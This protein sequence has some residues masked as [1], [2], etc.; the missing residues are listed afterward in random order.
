MPVAALVRE[1]WSEDAMERPSFRRVVHKLEA[2]LERIANSKRHAK[3]EAREVGG[4]GGPNREVVVVEEGPPQHP[5]AEVVAAAVMPSAAAGAAPVDA[6][7]EPDKMPSS[8]G[9]REGAD[10]EDATA[11]DRPEDEGDGITEQQHDLLENM[12]EEHLRDELADAPDFP[13]LV[14]DW[15]LLRFLGY[16]QDPK[17]ASAK[18]RRMLEW[19]RKHGVDAMRA[20]IVEERLSFETLPDADAI[21]EA[22]YVHTWSHKRTLEGDAILS[23]SRAC[24]AKSTFTDSSA[25]SVSREPCST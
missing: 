22:G 7:A 20:R 14:G 6:A 9:A 2:E 16:K 23:S 19:R 4:V 5:S 21:R 18:F 1:C 11:V 17:R 25:S 24:P 3:V 15:R 12:R 13:E 8:G 10:E